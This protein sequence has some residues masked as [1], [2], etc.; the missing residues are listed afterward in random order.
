MGVWIRHGVFCSYRSIRIDSLKLKFADIGFPLPMWRF[1]MIWSDSLTRWCRNRANFDRSFENCAHR[2][3]MMNQP[4]R[5]SSFKRLWVTV[6]KCMSYIYRNHMNSGVVCLNALL[7]PTTVKK[8]SPLNQLPS[9]HRVSG[10]FQP[11]KLASETSMDHMIPAM[12]RWP[13]GKLTNSGRKSFLFQDM[14]A[15]I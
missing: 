5:F 2:I 9:T 8:L 13:G 4:W 1:E 7:L 11:W 14:H 15:P 6:D 10:I 12:K 3:L